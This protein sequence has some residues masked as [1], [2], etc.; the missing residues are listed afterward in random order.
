LYPVTDGATDSPTF[1]VFCAVQKQTAQVFF[2]FSIVLSF[3]P[4]RDGVTGECRILHNVEL[5]DLYSS[6]NIVRVIKSKRVRWTGH[7]ARMGGKRRVQGFGGE[8]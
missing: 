4:K 1:N 8:T 2:F 6:P 7:V 5:N 3:G